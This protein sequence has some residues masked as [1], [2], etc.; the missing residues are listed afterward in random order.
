MRT[1]G[2]GASPAAR[3]TRGREG[4][5]TNYSENVC[6][7]ARAT[8]VYLC[9]ASEA[10]IRAASRVRGPQIVLRWKPAAPTSPHVCREVAVLVSLLVST[11]PSP[12]DLNHVLRFCH[13]L[14]RLDKGNVPILRKVDAI[15]VPEAG[16]EEPAMGDLLDA[17]VVGIHMIR[18]RT[19]K[20]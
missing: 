5:P 17:M 2:L 19:L 13:A 9:C 8:S 14:R 18:S 10:S 3:L 1:T 20:K 15:D 11:N 6:S 16:N 4:Q 7:F 12:G